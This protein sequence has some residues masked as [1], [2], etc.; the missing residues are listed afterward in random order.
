LVAAALA[1]QLVNGAV[2]TFV[3]VQHTAILQKLAL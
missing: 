2:A 1:V 3:E